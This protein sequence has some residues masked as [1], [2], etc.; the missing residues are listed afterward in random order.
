MWVLTVTNFAQGDDRSRPAM[1]I[2][3]AIHATKFK[4][5]RWDAVLG[6]ELARTSRS[7]RNGEKVA[8]QTGFLLNADDEPRTRGTPISMSRTPRIPPVRGSTGG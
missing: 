5:P 8:R 7:E 6:V 1:W 2:D 4:R 3:G